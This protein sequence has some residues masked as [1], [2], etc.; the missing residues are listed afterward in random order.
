MDKRLQ[1]LENWL[2]NDLGLTLQSLL[3]ASADA[4]FRR[5]FRAE[6]S[7]GTY[8]VMDAPPEL[9]PISDFI[10]IAHVLGQL[11]VHTPTIHEQ[12][13]EKGFLLLE[14]LGNTTFLD[15]L[16]RNVGPDNN[17][18]ANCSSAAKR[19]VDI[20]STLYE[21]AI[22]ALIKLQLGCLKRPEY[23]LPH[24]DANKLTQEMDLFEQWFASKHLKQNF[25]ASQVKTWASTK[26]SLI[27]ACLEQP[28][29]WVHRDYHSRNLMVTEQESPG[30]ID[31]QDMVVGPIGY[32]LA[33]IF[34]D[35][36]IEWPRADQHKWLEIYR[37][38]AIEQLDLSFDLEQLIRWVDLCGLQR[39]LKVLGI[40]C[41]LHY[42]DGKTRY[43]ADLPLVAKYVLEV[44]PLYPELSEF[45][46]MFSDLIERA[47]HPQQIHD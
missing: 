41:R 14:D 13:L 20:A 37:L 16:N 24:Y 38:Q 18:D 1:K 7:N 4:G 47:L 42:R 29:A 33:S 23:A 9:E 21:S 25:S 46:E 27:T 40:F 28:Q 6:T 15:A 17:H 10:S 12:D 34:K 44:L 3:R 22:N 31:F 36:Y 35:C 8:V 26:D 39:H 30:V 5:Y 32:D 11:G 43:L 2:I 19:S 45:E